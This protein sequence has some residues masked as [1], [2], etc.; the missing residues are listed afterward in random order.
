MA[1]S[2]PLR[3]PVRADEPFWAERA[4]VDEI[5]HLAAG[6]GSW[7]GFSVGRYRAARPTGISAGNKPASVFMMV[8]LLRPA[9]ERDIWR[10]SHWRRLPAANAGRLSFHDMAEHWVTDI[11]YP[12][13]SFH[14]YIPYTALDMIA[15]ELKCPKVETLITPEDSIRDMTLLGLVNALLPVLARPWEALSLFTDHVFTAMAVH[16][17]RHYSGMRCPAAGLC[18]PRAG[19]GLAQLRRA[20]SRLLDDITADISL[21]ALAAECGYSRGHFIR[22]F[23]Q[24]TG[25]PPYRWL[26]HERVKRARIYLDETTAPLADIALQCGFANQAHMTRIFTKLTGTSPGMWRRQRR[27]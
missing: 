8:V 5:Q 11:I 18:A 2:A 21:D 24:A 14:A 20:T 16:V 13:D 19:L 17:A 1:S 26:L 4:L 15:D 10:N 6:Q 7:P 12:V 27:Q 9:P 3:K 23:K 22:A 25:L